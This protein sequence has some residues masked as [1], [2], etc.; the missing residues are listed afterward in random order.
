LI[1]SFGQF[2]QFTPQRFGVRNLI[3]LMAEAM[4]HVRIANR[5]ELGA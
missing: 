3:E 4:R 1:F 2:S 5:F